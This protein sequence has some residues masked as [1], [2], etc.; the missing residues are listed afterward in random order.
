MYVRVLLVFIKIFSLYYNS[1]IYL[2][3]SKVFS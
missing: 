1:I 3:I 2:K